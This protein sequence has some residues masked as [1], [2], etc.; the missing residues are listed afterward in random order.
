MS[1]NN[2]EAEE[3]ASFYSKFRLKYVKWTCQLISYLKENAERFDA[4]NVKTMISIGPGEYDY[5]V[6]HHA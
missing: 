5:I 6:I 1:G 2:T 3:F 4:E